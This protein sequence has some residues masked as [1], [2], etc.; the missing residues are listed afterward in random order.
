MKKDVKT[1]ILETAR[2]LFNEQGYNGVS[3]RDIAG[4]LGIS[5]GNLTYYFKRKEDLLEA[6]ALRQLEGY[7]KKAPAAS[8]AELDG[9]FRRKLAFQKGNAYYF[10]HYTQLAQIS[11]KVYEMQRG[12]IRDVSGLQVPW[13]DD[14]RYRS[15]TNPASDS[16]FGDRQPLWH[17]DGGAGW[18]AAA[19]LLEPDLA[20]ADGNGKKGI[21]GRSGAARRR[22]IRTGRWDTAFE[23]ISHADRI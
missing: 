21:P 14:G 15:G 6:V 17:G 1:D 4:A 20:H 8:L 19:L 7:Q 12:I 16:G 18:G 13:K 10:R 2:K 23:V 22:I 5:V 3:M 11:P 9:H